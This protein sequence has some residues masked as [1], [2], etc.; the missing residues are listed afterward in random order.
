MILAGGGL[1]GRHPTS[2]A[3]APEAWTPVSRSGPARSR[4]PRTATRRLRSPRDEPRARRSRRGA[5]RPLLGVPAGPRRVAGAGRRPRRRP[6]RRHRRAAAVVQRQHHPRGGPARSAWCSSGPDTTADAAAGRRPRPRPGTP[7]TDTAAARLL[8]DPPLRRRLPGVRRRAAAPGDRAGCPLA[9]RP[10]PSA[11][12][13]QDA[14]PG[15][16]RTTPRQRRDG[17]PRRR[18]P[19]R[20]GVVHASRPARAPGCSSRRPAAWPASSGATVSFPSAAGGRGQRDQR[21]ASAARRASYRVHVLLPLRPPGHRARHLGRR[22]APRRLR[23]RRGRRR[24]GGLRHRRRPVRAQVGVSFV[25]AGGARRNLADGGA[26][27][28]LR[29][30]ARRRRAGLGARAGPGRRHRRQRRPSGAVLDTALYHVLLHPMTLSD[31]DGRYPG[32]DGAVH[33]VAAGHRQLHRDPRL[34]R[35]PHHGAAA[36]LAA[37]GR[38][39]RPR[40]LAATRR[41][42]GRAGCPAG[43]WSRRTPGS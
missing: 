25:D 23:D 27:L 12:A 26:G 35:L 16:Y 3:R 31:A 1:S 19:R 7:P 29:P 14:G 32:F 17:V 40:R 11:W 5:G 20:A 10:R 13:E 42:R 9:P 22:P 30:P 28:V 39:L 33:R 8:P 18:R 2:V 6:V 43:R 34:G 21:R 38:R 41:R 4:D 37:P 24:L 36:G 15:W